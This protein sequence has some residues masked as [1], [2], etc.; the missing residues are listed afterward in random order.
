MSL[1][2]A[3]KHVIYPK[4]LLHRL[5][6]YNAFKGNFNN[7]YAFTGSNAYRAKPH[8]ECERNYVRPD[9]GNWKEKEFFSKVENLN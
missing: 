4:S 1:S 9:E 2:T 7:G 5:Q 8:N 6:L 3:L